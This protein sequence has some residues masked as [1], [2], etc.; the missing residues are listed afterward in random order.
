MFVFK[1]KFKIRYPILSEGTSPNVV[2]VSGA[3]SGSTKYIFTEPL[4]DLQTIS[5]IFRNPDVPIIFDPDFFECNSFIDFTESIPTLT[6]KFP[7]HNLLT[8]DILNIVN[9]NTGFIVLDNYI[10]RSNILQN[11][12]LGIGAGLILGAAPNS[13]CPSPKLPNSNKI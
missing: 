3:Y 5:L 10:N 2:N 1:L 8:G 12:V 4:I 7:S 11:G 13:D 9:F 6:F